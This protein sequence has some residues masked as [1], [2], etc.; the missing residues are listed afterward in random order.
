M[1][2]LL[3]MPFQGLTIG[4]VY[5]RVVHNRA[6]PPLVAFDAAQERCAE[7]RP[8]LVAYTALLEA[9]WSAEPSMRPSFKQVHALH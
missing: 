5:S 3:Q 2:L 7:E 9:C 4:Q 1:C 8:A 6:R